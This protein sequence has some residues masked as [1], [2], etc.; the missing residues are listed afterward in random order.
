MDANNKASYRTVLPSEI[1]C[2]AQVFGDP[3]PGNPKTYS[4]IDT[5]ILPYPRI[6]CQGNNR[7]HSAPM[8]GQERAMYVDPRP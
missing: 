5:A 7:I 4:Y 3:S 2:N 8:G 1:G 6:Q